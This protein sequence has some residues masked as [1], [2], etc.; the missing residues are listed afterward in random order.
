MS[1]KKINNQ[2]NK[3][4]NKKQSKKQAQKPKKLV[5]SHDQFFKAIY[6]YPNLCKDLLWLIFSKEELEIYNANKLKIEKDTF[7]GHKGELRADLVFSIPFKDNPQI[8]IKVFILLE[9]KSY[10]DKGF[11]NTMLR[12]LFAMREFLFQQTGKIH[13]IIPVLF[14]HG[15]EPFKRKKSL[16]EDDFKD[17]FTKM[18]RETSESM[19]N[20]KPKI[21]NTHDPKLI[22]IYQEKGFKSTGV[23]KLLTDIWRLKK[24]NTISSEQIIDIYNENKKLLE[25]LEKEEKKRVILTIHEYIKAHAKVMEQTWKE[26][27]EQLIKQGLLTKGVKYGRCKRIF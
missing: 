15:K 22:K 18:S 11:Y 27:E 24:N 2:I 13:P 12:Y 17:F 6:S 19:L 14:Y 26:V 4:V 25:N 16:Q 23:I 10:Y 20:Y 9:H 7:K 21:I 5:L 3:K 1:N 8:S